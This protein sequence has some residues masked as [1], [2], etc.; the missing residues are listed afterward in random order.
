MRQA[1][2]RQDQLVSE[3][4]STPNWT[5]INIS[6]P[7][8]FARFFKLLAYEA[9]GVLIDEGETV[10]VLGELSRGGR[11]DHR[12]RKDSLGLR[13][14]GNA[15]L[16]DG[17]LHWIAIG[18]G[19]DALTISAD[20]G[21]NAVASRQ[22]S[23]DIVRRIAPDLEL[24]Q[25]AA[26]EFAIEKNPR[27]LCV[28]IAFFALLGFALIDGLMLNDNTLLDGKTIIAMAPFFGLLGIACYP[29]LTRGGV[30]SRESLVLCILL[31]N[32]LGG[33]FV[34]LVKRADQW[35]AGGSR[36]TVVY[37]LQSKGRFIP[38]SSTAP[39]IDYSQYREYWSQFEPGS[40]HAFQL[41][42]GPLGL[43]QL[44]QTQQRERLRAFYEKNE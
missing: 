23:A 37:E 40:S 41:I 11:I 15:R 12:Y 21:L 38:A 9:R 28:V 22:A 30:P 43:W 6:R 20:T 3:L 10:R 26:A 33:A 31:G 5:R 14:L 8:H 16:A 1:R 7:S 39:E 32:A 27:S 19:A 34:P 44:E 35:A 4:R 42:H 13:W 29:V 36:V 2:R 24:P 18:Q 25:S 17:S